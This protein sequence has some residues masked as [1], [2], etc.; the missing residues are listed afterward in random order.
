MKDQNTHETSGNRKLLNLLLL[1]APLVVVAAL[2][3]FARQDAPDKPAPPAN[4]PA[5]ETPLDSQAAE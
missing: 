2:L 1:L 3:A 4:H 5:A